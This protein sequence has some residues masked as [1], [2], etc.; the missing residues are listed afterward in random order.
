MKPIRSFVCICQHAFNVSHITRYLIERSNRNGFALPLSSILSDHLYDTND[1][2]S[3]IFHSQDVN[4][5]GHTHG[6]GKNTG[7]TIISIFLFQIA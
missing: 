3:L 4:A 6:M 7:N 1:E 5:V 2:N